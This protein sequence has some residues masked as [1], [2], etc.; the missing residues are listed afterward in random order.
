MP[1]YFIKGKGE[2]TLSKSDFRAAGGFGSV[3]VKGSTAYK[4]YHDPANMIPVA[5]ISELSN[6]TEPYIVRPRAIILDSK[7]KPVGYTMLNINNGYALCQM[8]PKAFRLRKNLDVNNT[9]NLVQKLREGVGFV[10]SKDSLI[11]DLN[12]MNFMITDKFDQVY[13]LD[14]DSYQT[15]SFKATSLMDSI[16][17][18]HC[19]NKQFNTGTDWF[20]FGIV[21]FQ[22]FVGIHP[23]KG[24]YIPLSNIDKDKR[25]DA[26]MLQNISVLHKD[27]TIPSVTLDFSN[28]PNSYRQW[29]EAVFERGERVAPPKDMQAVVVIAKVQRLSGSNNFEI[30]DFFTGDG[31]IISINHDIIVTSKFIY[32]GHSILAPSQPDVKIGFTP[33]MG[34]AVSAHCEDG[35]VKLFNLDTKKPIDSYIACQDLMSYEGSLYCRFENAVYQ[36]DFI[37]THSQVMATGKIVGNVMEKSSQV[38]DGVIMQNMLGSYFAMIFPEPGG[39]YEFKINELDGYQVIDA[40]FSKGVLMVVGNKGGK[41]DKFVIRF[42]KDYYT[43]DIRVSNDIVYSGLNFVVLDNGVCINL[44]EKDEVMV[45]RSEKDATLTKVIT[46]PSI[47]SDSKLFSVGVSTIIA[48][49]NNAHKIKMK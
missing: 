8:F 15:K 13:F 38:F 16:R 19:H 40:K 25:L 47:K 26:R 23:F 9:A 45:F 34:Y 5:K 49:G 24:T 3:Y 17:D 10:H 35:E 4:I 39:N 27:V 44:N 21:S 14:V 18:R 28:I 6:L 41:Y 2:I 20:A 42:S 29:Y 7:N 12:E 37:E 11:V 36:V 30:N 48:H 33:K 22:M 32:R 43:K 1:K 31:D 46:D